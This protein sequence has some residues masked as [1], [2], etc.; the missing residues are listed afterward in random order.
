VC[1]Q[2][3]TSEPFEPSGYAFTPNRVAMPTRFRKDYRW[4]RDTLWA[5]AF[6][7]LCIVVGWVVS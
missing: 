5:V 6:T 4:L 1:D 7:A 2:T 3:Q